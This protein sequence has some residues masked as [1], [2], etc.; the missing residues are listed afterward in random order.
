MGFLTGVAMGGIA[1]L[2]YA[3]EKEER[4]IRAATS[5]RSREDNGPV[6]NMDVHIKDLKESISEFVEEVHERFEAVESNLQKHT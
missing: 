5:E 4:T 1:G 2:V 3:L 6:E